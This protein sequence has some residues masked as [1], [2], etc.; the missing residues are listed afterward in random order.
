M[1]AKVKYLDKEIEGLKHIGGDKRSCWMDVRVS[2]VEVNGQEVPFQDG[3]INKGL[4][5]IEGNLYRHVKEEVKDVVGYKQG[6]VV[7]VYL[8][9]AM[10]LP[11]GYE[12]LVLPRSS[13]FK[14][15]GLIQVNSMGVIDEDYNGDGDEW[16][17]NYVAL[18][19]GFITKGDRVGQFR[20]QEKM[21]GL[22]LEVV[23][24]LNNADRGGEGSTGKQ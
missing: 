6:D 19:D 10:E 9:F 20:V 7:K 14:H 12:A 13:T 11:E 24:E 18:R 17:V 8:G 1:K 21:K 23:E 15:Y 22:E 2:K 4:E 16:F 3:E 5:K